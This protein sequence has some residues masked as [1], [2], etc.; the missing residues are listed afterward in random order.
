MGAAFVIQGTECRQDE[1]IR[2]TSLMVLLPRVLYLHLQETLPCK[3][4]QLVSWP[5]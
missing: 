3:S 5:C 1:G 4:L 2:M